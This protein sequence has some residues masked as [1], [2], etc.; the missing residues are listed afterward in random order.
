VS[1]L[2][3]SEAV[4]WSQAFAKREWRLVLPVALAF[5]GLPFM[6]FRLFVPFPVTAPGTLPPF[7]PGMLWIVPVL[8][9]NL[10]G[11]I[12]ITAMVLVPGISVREALQVGTRRF[13]VLVAAWLMIG[14]GGGLIVILASVLVLFL[15]L[16]LGL[17]Q[18]AAATIVLALGAPLSLLL[19]VRLIMLAP[20]VV[21]RALGPV[22]ALKTS[23]AITR[24]HFWPLAAILALMLL[25]TMILALAVQSAFG[26]VALLLAKLLGLK[27]L[28]VVLIAI[29]AALINSLTSAAFYIVIAALYPQL[30]GA[31]RGM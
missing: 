24:G 22:A 12:A 16:L 28:G 14:L 31:S 25:A 13:W 6:L 10:I 19:F 26:V 1:R 21:S 7:A 3:V 27:A 11:A 20:L 30:G 15:S 2:S 17:N 5:I 23:W 18:Q 9:L 8:L 29:S 4:T